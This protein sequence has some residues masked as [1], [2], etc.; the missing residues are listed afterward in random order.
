MLLF[1]S[2]HPSPLPFPS[3]V[4][5]HSLLHLTS[6]PT[7]ASRQL[8]SLVLGG[9]G[10]FGIVTAARIKTSAN[11]TLSSER[12]SATVEDFPDIYAGILADP[13]ID[14]KLCRLDIT[15][16]DSISIYT[17]RS[18]SNHCACTVSPIGFMA[19]EP[20]AAQRLLYKWAAPALKELRFAIEQGS[21]SA[22]DWSEAADR[23]SLLYESARPLSELSSPLVQVDDTF[24]LQEFFV[25]SPNFCKWME[26]TK[27]IFT[28]L[29][30]CSEICL[31]NCT[32]RFVHHDRDTVLNYAAAQQGCFAFVLYYRLPRTAKADALLAAYH[33][34]FTQHTLSLGGT[35]YLPYRHHYSQQEL[36]KA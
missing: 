32:I 16:A 22:S 8:F 10:L 19:R 12:I 3:A 20:S 29:N 14:I 31:L 4:P 30:S 33:Q 5:F 36:V 13:C 11:Q 23:N 9:Y 28:S 17:F 25:P 26:K 1:L 34:R 6:G 21:S 24:I 35:F 2:H 18:V 15:S 7:A 27:A